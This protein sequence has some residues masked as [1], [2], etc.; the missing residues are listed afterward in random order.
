MSSRRID[1]GEYLHDLRTTN[2]YSQKKVADKLGIDISLLSKIEYGE[3]QL[4]SHMIAPLAELFKIDY[5]SIQIQFINHR[6]LE[7]FG[8][9]PFIEEAVSQFLNERIK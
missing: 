7:E 3:R 6:I 1:F 2:C 9:E 5:K 4:Q 8:N